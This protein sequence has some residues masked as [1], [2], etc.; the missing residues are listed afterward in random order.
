MSAVVEEASRA[1]KPWED[2]LNP[3]LWHEIFHNHLRPELDLSAAAL[4]ALRSLSR[5]F[6]L[7]VRPLMYRH[8]NLLSFPRAVA[9][10]EIVAEN[11]RL[12]RSVRTLQFSFDMGPFNTDSDSDSDS[13]MEDI[14]NDA[15]SLD[16]APLRDLAVETEFWS[17]LN[18]GLPNL[19]CLTTLSISYDHA[20]HDFL[21]HFLRMGNLAQTLPASVAKVHLKPLPAEYLLHPK[22]LHME[23]PWNTT[24]WRLQI[25]QIPN[26]RQLLV[27]TP[28]YIV[29]PPTTDQLRLT[30]AAWTAQLRH[31]TSRLEEIV[32]YCG[33]GDESAAFGK[34]LEENEGAEIADEFAEENAV[35]GAQ[36]VWR[37]VDKEWVS[38]D[39]LKTSD[40]NREEYFFGSEGQEYLL[41]WL[42]ID[43]EMYG[44]DW[45]LSQELE[46]GMMGCHVVY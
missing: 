21:H 31:S 33:F 4:P 14:D 12:A 41:P 45:R 6:A 16:S 20:Q 23:G 15:N 37:P 30:I 7:V 19:I 24:S 36:M 9:F 26:I 27:T 5:T 35:V 28:T 18:K 34:W 46:K 40:S 32:V 29:W 1:P 8:V 25:S 44:E 42:F 43:E 17:L 11:L 10:F 2:P 39:I 22:D 38:V 3:D 13:D